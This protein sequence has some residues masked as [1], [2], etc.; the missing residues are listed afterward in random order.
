MSRPYVDPDRLGDTFIATLLTD[1]LKEVA[2]AFARSNKTAALLTISAIEREIL[3]R[4]EGLP[5]ALA[6]PRLPR[7]TRSR[8]LAQVAAAMSDAQRAAEETSL[9]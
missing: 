3:G 6:S 8:V 1:A 4:V 2:T 7:T 5:G 9:Q